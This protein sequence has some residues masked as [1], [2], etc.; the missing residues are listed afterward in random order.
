M[1]LEA[2]AVS[3]CSGRNCRCFRRYIVSIVD[4][5]YPSVPEY[6]ACKSFVG[7]FPS[8]VDASSF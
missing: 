2:A 6:R 3:S 8:G 4:V 1:T 7:L 5:V